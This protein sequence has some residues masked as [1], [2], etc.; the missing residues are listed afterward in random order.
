MKYN[1]ENNIFD[2]NLIK[3][4]IQNKLNIQT[5]EIN[6]L[7]TI[8]KLNENKENETNIFNNFKIENLILIT[9]IKCN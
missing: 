1:I 2:L 6:Q 9:I 5:N 8:L 4:K 3:Q 7:I